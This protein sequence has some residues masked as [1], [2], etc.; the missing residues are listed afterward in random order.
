MRYTSPILNSLPQQ[1][2]SLNNPLVIANSI[3]PSARNMASLSETRILE[4]L[5]QSALK[6][7]EKK[8]G[9]N[10]VGHPLAAQLEHCDNVESITDV[11]QGQARAF[12]GF[13][14]GNERVRR[15][16]NLTVQVLHKLT[17]TASLVES[18]GLVC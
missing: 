14:G 17:G 11:L 3:F 1:P 18:I 12:L 8:T 15:M 16:L 2:T 9:V 4:S 5:F 6:E 13:R 10:L 7:Y